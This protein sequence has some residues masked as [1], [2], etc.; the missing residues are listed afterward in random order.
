M[1]FLAGYGTAVLG[2]AWLG[3]ARRGSARQ[4]HSRT[5]LR[6]FDSTGASRGMAGQGKV[7]HG[8]ARQGEARPGKARLPAHR[9]SA[10]RLRACGLRRGKAGPGQAG[11]GKAQQGKTR[12]PSGTCFQRGDVMEKVTFQFVGTSAM[13]MHSAR[14]V[15]QRDPLVIE[16]KKYTSARKKTEETIAAAQRLEWELGMYFD[17]KLGPY[18]PTTN[19]RSVIVEG[20]KLN[21][22]GMAVKRAVVTLDER[23][24]LDYE[25]PR[26]IEA[27]WKTGSFHDVRSVGVGQSRVMRCRPIFREWSTT[28]DLVF[29]GEVIERAQLVT[30]AESAGQLV[31][32][33]DFRVVNGGPFGR[34]TVTAK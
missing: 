6:W 33:G 4:G 16:L 19:L 24:R 20:A 25:G 3:W 22:L 34:F 8:E 32:L 29:D 11:H 23:A 31:G 10:V 2:P 9:E 7:G 28:F 15:D 30:A 17:P 21:K 13:L 26:D 12:V 1:K 27:M 14:G 5:G 18:V